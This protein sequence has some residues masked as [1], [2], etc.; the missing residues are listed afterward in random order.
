MKVIQ[1][2]GI[3]GLISAVFIGACL[4]AGFVIFPGYSA[5]AL[6]NKYL[7]TN[8]MFP[9]LN[10]MQG[11]LLW[12]IIAITYCI[13]AKQGLALSFKSTPDLTEDEIKDIIK[14]AKISS[15]MKMMSNMVSKSDKLDLHKE[16]IS[17]P[18]SV[19]KDSFMSSPISVNKNSDKIE[20]ES[21][22][23]VK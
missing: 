22:S 7:V 5:M 1:I 2:D 15:K 20:E 12:A 23:N 19:E 14:N 8:L 9:V 18:V 10:L 11:V 6:W 16:E 3:K 4:V 13:V 17:K 21:V